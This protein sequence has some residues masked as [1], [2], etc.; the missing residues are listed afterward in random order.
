MIKM[1]KKVD[2][3]DPKKWIRRVILAL[4]IWL[5][6]AFT[7]ILPC[8]LVEVIVVTAIADLLLESVI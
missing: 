3:G 5:V 7:H 2:I 6:F 1:A 8:G 4:I